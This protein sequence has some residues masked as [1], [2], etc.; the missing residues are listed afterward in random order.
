MKSDRSLTQ[1]KTN[2][3]L[4]V[5]SVLLT[6][7]AAAN[8]QVLQAYFNFGSYGT[9]AGGGTIVNQTGN[10]TTTATLNNDANTS[11]TS[12]DLT[13]TAGPGG[14]PIN[15]GLMFASDS[16]NS[17]TGSFTIQDWITPASGSGMVLFGGRRGQVTAAA[18]FC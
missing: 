10:T 17:F 13:I 6:F 1:R 18:N 8:A 9:V 15:T 14:N 11:L 12:N 16:L 2:I 5:S 4:S 7:T 3:V